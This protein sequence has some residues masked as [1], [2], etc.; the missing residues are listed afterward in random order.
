METDSDRNDEPE[1]KTFSVTL[2]IKALAILF[3]VAIYAVI[4]LKILFLR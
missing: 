4:F 1:Y 2:F 3:V